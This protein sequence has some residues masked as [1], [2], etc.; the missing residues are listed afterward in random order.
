[1]RELV[2]DHRLLRHYAVNMYCLNQSPRLEARTVRLQLR[3]IQ[4]NHTYQWSSNGLRSCANCLERSNERI[5]K[6]LRKL[7]I[8]LLRPNV[9]LYGKDGDTFLDDVEERPDLV[10]VAGMSPASESI[11]SLVEQLGGKI[12]WVSKEK[13]SSKLKPLFDYVYQGDCDAIARLYNLKPRPHRLTYNRLCE[14]DDKLTD[15][16][17]DHVRF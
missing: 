4:C 13:P 1:M 5:S 11:R 15:V 10:L 12:F 8:G 6:G 17:V 7:N 14:Y 2:N 3:C 16:L 9:L